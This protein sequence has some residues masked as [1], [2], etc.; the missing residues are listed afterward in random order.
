VAAAPPA[1]PYTQQDFLNLRR[2]EFDSKLQKKENEHRELLQKPV[3]AEIDF[4][5]KAPADGPIANIGELMKLE[6]EKRNRDIQTMF[7]P[8]P[9]VG[10]STPAAFSAPSPTAAQPPQ[11]RAFDPPAVAQPASALKKSVSWKDE[12]PVITNEKLY[13]LYEKIASDLE[14]IKILLENK[15]S[16]TTPPP[17]FPEIYNSSENV[18][19]TESPLI[20]KEEEEKTAMEAEDK[21]PSPVE[22]NVS[23]VESAVGE[24]EVVLQSVPEPAPH[25]VAD[26]NFYNPVETTPPAAPEN[27]RRRRRSR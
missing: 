24:T 22:E 9:G 5:D 6:I 12:E 1:V 19:D 11:P 10:A 15:F 4:R 8:L 23:I 13:N 17:K 18:K 2:N 14:Y 3:P 20:K 21:T 25:A 16:A 7:S 26:M 27:D